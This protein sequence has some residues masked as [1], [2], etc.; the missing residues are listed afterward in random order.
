M[1]HIGLFFLIYILLPTLFDF[2]LEFTTIFGS[3]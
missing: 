2:Y 1:S 3:V